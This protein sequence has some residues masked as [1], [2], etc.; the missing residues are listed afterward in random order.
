MQL[1]TYKCVKEV[2]QEQAHVGRTKKDPVSNQKFKYYL[3][4]N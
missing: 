1:A 2:K 4:S 3:I